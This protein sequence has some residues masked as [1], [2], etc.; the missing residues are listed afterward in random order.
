MWLLPASHCIQQRHKTLPDKLSPKWGI[1]CVQLITLHTTL[2]PS[3][4]NDE[5]TTSNHITFLLKPFLFFFLIR[6]PAQMTNKQPPT[7]LP[8]KCHCHHRHHHY[9]LL[10]NFSSCCSCC[11]LLE[12][13]ISLAFRF[14]FSF[15]SFF[16]FF[17][18]LMFLIFKKV[19]ALRFVPCKALLL[20]YLFAVVVLDF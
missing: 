11:R 13:D 16:F 2:L 8:L 10:K 17:F 9:I 15:P 5:T 14:L 3:K 20:Y 19:V 4:R 7:L 1:C 18:L 6:I 12:R